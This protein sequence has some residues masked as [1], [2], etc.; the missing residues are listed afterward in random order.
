M[1]RSSLARYIRGSLLVAGFLLH[2]FLAS[3]RTSAALGVLALGLSASLWVLISNA[4]NPKRTDTFAEVLP[5]SAMN[6]PEGLSVL[7]TPD[8]VRIRVRAPEDIWRRLSV[9]SFTARADLS[10]VAAGTQYVP[11]RVTSKLWQAKVVDVIPGNVEVQV[12][13]YGEAVVPVRVNVHNVPALGYSAGSPVYE[14][15]QVA[16]SGPQ[17]LV[18]EIEWAAADVDLT[19]ARLSIDRAYQLTPQTSSG[20]LVDGVQLEPDTVRVSLPINQDVYYQSFGVSPKLEG[21]AAAGYWVSALNVEPSTVTLAGSLSALESLRYAETE[22]IS[23]TEANAT[24]TRTVK[25]DLPKGV[26]AAG[27]DAVTVEVVVSPM[28]GSKTFWVA[29]TVLGL[30]SDLSAYLASAVA[31]TVSGPMSVLERLTESDLS[32]EIDL[33]G[34]DL[35]TYTIEPEVRVPSEVTFVSLVP[36]VI[37]LT[38]R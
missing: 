6:V 19:A 14:P 27:P 25:L 32:V 4:E 20:S 11:V 35:G 5:V 1:F 10:G 23:L 7:G 13:P 34:F 36:Q 15:Q 8:T 17:P 9:D 33:T 30:R 37:M 24:F 21:S 22:A 3:L 38:V 2:R 29:P 12:A 28:T 31:V 26:S 18:D 16:V